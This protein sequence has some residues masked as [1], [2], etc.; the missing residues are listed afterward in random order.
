MC[1]VGNGLSGTLEI[2]SVQFETWDTAGRTQGS[3]GKFR[4]IETFVPTLG[5][6]PTRNSRTFKSST[7]TGPTLRP[8]GRHLSYSPVPGVGRR[9]PDERRGRLKV[10]DR[11]RPRGVKEGGSKYVWGRG[12]DS[13][14]VSNS[15]GVGRR[16]RR[17][18]VC[19]LV[20]THACVG[21]YAKGPRDG[22][23]PVCSRSRVDV[24]VVSK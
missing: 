11:R 6:S 2:V 19:A 10:V 15:A 3:Q 22:G 21:T 4:P 1:P 13:C 24:C 12:R 18:E 23:V 14:I 5:P 17:D 16:V 8:P 20:P 7:A 9:A